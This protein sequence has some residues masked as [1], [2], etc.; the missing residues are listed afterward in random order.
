MQTFPV[1]TNRPRARMWMHRNDRHQAASQKSLN[2][3]HER[4]R[5]FPEI[6]NQETHRTTVHRI[7]GRRL[8]GTLITDRSITCL[9]GTHVWYFV[10]TRDFSRLPCSACKLLPP[11]SA[12]SVARVLKE[13]GFMYDLAKRLLEPSLDQAHMNSHGQ[14]LLAETH[15][16]THFSVE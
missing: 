8:V 4:E 12:M 3:Q 14:L 5:E 2:N 15:S 13:V 11:F 6:V 7:R 1:L 9:D 10:T 16:G